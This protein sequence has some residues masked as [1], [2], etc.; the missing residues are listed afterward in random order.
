VLV[1]SDGPCSTARSWPATLVTFIAP[2][3]A[4]SPSG[5]EGTAK[6]LGDAPAGTIPADELAGCLACLI[7]AALA[8]IIATSWTRRTA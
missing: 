5:P 3:V 2:V 6:A 4:G 8:A 1:F 7:L